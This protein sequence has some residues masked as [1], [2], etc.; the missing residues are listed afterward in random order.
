MV[1][2]AVDEVEIVEDVVTLR[3]LFEE[4]LAAPNCSKLELDFGSGGMDVFEKPCFFFFNFYFVLFFLLKFDL[5][6]NLG[7]S[8]IWTTGIQNL[9]VLFLFR[10]GFCD[11]SVR[12]ML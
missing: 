8:K 4:T 5:C 11:P 10:L 7:V 1:T 2:S 3:P 9:C 6:V 12:S